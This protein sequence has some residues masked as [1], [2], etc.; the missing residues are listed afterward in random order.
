MI[1]AM[2]RFGKLRGMFAENVQGVLESFVQSSQA[3]FGPDLISIVLY[4]SG[5]EGKLRASSDVNVILVL[6]KFEPAAVDLIR[7]PW[8]R[9]AVVRGRN[10]AASRPHSK[11]FW[12]AFTWMPGSAPYSLRTLLDR[13]SAR[14]SPR[15]NVRLL[16]TSAGG[17]ATGRT[18]F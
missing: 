11:H 3:A 15:Q 6:G 18:V 2:V 1:A 7:G 17:P 13:P 10:K 12:H 5:A 14:A 9:A 16:K 8:A 4:G